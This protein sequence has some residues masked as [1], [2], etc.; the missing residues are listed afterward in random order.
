MNPQKKNT[1]STILKNLRLEKKI[2]QRELAQIT[3]LSISSIIS[4]E[5]GLREPNSKAMAALERYFDVSG[6]FLRGNIDKENFYEKSA[7]I[8]ST[9]DYS[10]SL[11]AELKEQLHFSSQAK[12]EAAINYL[13]NAILFILKYVLPDE[14]PE[15]D[16]EILDSLISK[17]LTL[18]QLGKNELL[19][20]ADELNQLKLYIS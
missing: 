4:Y 9:L 11:M 12:Q 18:N 17:Y 19:K 10:I 13:N 14:A 16:V 5:N 8:Q 3:G 20:R 2:T 1:M 15:L 7:Q 6:D